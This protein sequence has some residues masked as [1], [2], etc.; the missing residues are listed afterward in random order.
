MNSFLL[1]IHFLCTTICSNLFFWYK[2]FLAY[3]LVKVVMFQDYLIIKISDFW[4]IIKCKC[5]FFKNIVIIYLSWWIDNCKRAVWNWQ[6]PI[7]NIL[8]LLILIFQFS[9]YQEED[10]YF[11]WTHPISFERIRMI[12]AKNSISVLICFNNTYQ[13]FLM[14]IWTYFESKNFKV[15][16]ISYKLNKLRCTFTNMFNKY[17][18]FKVFAFKS[19][20]F[21][22]LCASSFSLTNRLHFSWYLILSTWI[23]GLLVG[24]EFIKKILSF[25]VEYKDIFLPWVISI[26]NSQ[27]FASP[28]I[29]PLIFFSASN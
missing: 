3:P 15:F 6:Y 10:T 17:F 4:F 8:E 19:C 22:W 9:M 14:T 27:I 13:E 2:L 25:L 11:S 18:L 20:L 12:F 28:I 5:N 23:H 29:W 16:V 1:L 26:R 24:F 21:F 7:L